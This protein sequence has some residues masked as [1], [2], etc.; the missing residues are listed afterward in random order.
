MNSS[1]NA[2]VKLFGAIAAIVTGVSVFVPFY[3]ISILGSTISIDLMDMKKIWLIVLII[4]AAGLIFTLA[5]VYALT[6][7]CGLGGLGVFIY[8]YFE[9]DHLV[10][11]SDLADFVSMIAKNILQKDAGFYM[12]LAGSIGLLIAGILGAVQKRSAG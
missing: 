6:A 2:G 7:L 9:L 4:A 3:K 8:L 11:G 1:Q 5:G 12:L 10:S